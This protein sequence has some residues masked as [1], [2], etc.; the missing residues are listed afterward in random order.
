MKEAMFAVSAL[1]KLR[2]ELIRRRKTRK[3]RRTP[4][5]RNF[6]LDYDSHATL[7]QQEGCYI[8][9]VGMPYLSFVKLVTILDPYMPSINER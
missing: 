9:A 4:H 6:N 5:D 2:K 1:I 7:L 3:F 8:E